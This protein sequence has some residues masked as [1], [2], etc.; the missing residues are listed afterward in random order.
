MTDFI[1]ELFEHYENLLQW[2]II[3]I[4]IIVLLIKRDNF[5]NTGW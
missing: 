3:G 1:F 2:I 5:N 4:I